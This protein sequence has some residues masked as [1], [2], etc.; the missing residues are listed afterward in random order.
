MT[1]G[2]RAPRPW[3][4]KTISILTLL[5]MIGALLLAF[6]LILP[7]LLGYE[8]YVIVS[9]SMEPTVPVGAVIYDEVVP[10]QDIETGDII[11]FVPPPE[12]GID[13]PVTHRVIE[14]SI[15]G[16]N[17]SQPGARLFRTKGDANE[18]PDAWKMVL[19]GPDQ[20]R[21]VHHIP[22]VG[23]VYMALHVRWVQVL[24]IGLPA[25]ALVAYL[26]TSLWRLSAEGVREERRR[27]QEP[28]QSDQ[29]DQPDQEQAGAVS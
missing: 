6:I 19:D 5:M 4:Q 24:L 2:P 18:D 7:T 22:Y 25:L 11:T 16:E 12:Y 14:I 10:V 20:A 17:T 8:R 3:L 29:P 28:D 26:G 9:G 27:E 15:A 23:Y 13:D 21:Y 1:A